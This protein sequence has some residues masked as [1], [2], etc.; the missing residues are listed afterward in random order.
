[1][2]WHPLD[3]SNSA[4]VGE[5]VPNCEAKV[6]AEDEVTK[7]GR[8]Q[9]GEI[10]VRGPNIMKG[11]WRNTK[12]TKD[13]LT[14]DGWLKSGDIGYVDDQGKWYIVDRKKVRIFY[15]SRSGILFESIFI[16]V[17]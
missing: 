4:C 15:R 13:T 5:L 1:M 8:N 14:Q 17:P 6:I 9:R 2:A 3:R 11:Y 7:L 16:D 10:W 12:A